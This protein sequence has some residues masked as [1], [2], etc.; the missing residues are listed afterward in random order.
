MLDYVNK[1]ILKRNELNNRIAALKKLI[2]QTYKTFRKLDAE[3]FEIKVL[4]SQHP[5]QINIY[6][7]KLNEIEENLEMERVNIRSYQKQLS[8][9]ENIRLLEPTASFTL[10]KPRLVK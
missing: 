1:N 3:K 8:K 7:I 6:Q 2:Q 4:I 10:S 5:D 9:L